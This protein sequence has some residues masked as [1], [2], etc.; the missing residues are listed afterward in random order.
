MQL[1]NT[2]K[3]FK[4]SWEIGCCVITGPDPEGGA[5]GGRPSMAAER[6]PQK[7]TGSKSRAP[8]GVQGHSLWKLLNFK[9]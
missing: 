1:Q 5:W 9:H 3:N 8:V 7:M 2:K 6:R 4:I